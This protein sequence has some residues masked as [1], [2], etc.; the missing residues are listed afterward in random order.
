MR[1][2]CLVAIASQGL[3]RRGGAGKFGD[4]A[5]ER[6]RK[7][8][9]NGAVAL[10]VWHRVGGRLG[11]LFWRGGGGGV[12]APAKEQEEEC[13]QNK[14]ADGNTDAQTYFGALREACGFLGLQVVL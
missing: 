6:S 11:R 10:A 14:G 5:R 4:V 9:R 1:P 8:L 12:S 3:G 13:R 7:G 2:G